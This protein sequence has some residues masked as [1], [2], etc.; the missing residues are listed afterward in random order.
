[1]TRWLGAVC[2]VGMALAGIGPMSAG[3]ETPDRGAEIYADLCAGCHGRYGRGDGPLAA[4]LAVDVPD[5][6]DPAWT[7]GRS[8][9]QIVDGLVGASH[10]PMAI[11]RVLERDAL[12]DAV[13][14]IRTLAGPGGHVSRAEGR[15]IYNATC[16]V[17]HGRDGDGQGPAAANL[18]GPAPRDFTSPEF[19]I[20]GREDE[21][22]RTIARGAEAS[23]HGSPLMPEWGSSL[24]ERQVRGLVEYLKTFQQR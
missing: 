7:A 10:A 23:F 21:I 8:T 5:F 20:E 2:A 22:A 1:M 19:T 24:S 4:D 13:A 14:Y 18:E 15:D 11:A 12:R 3:A 17:C 6:T 16:W 9:Q